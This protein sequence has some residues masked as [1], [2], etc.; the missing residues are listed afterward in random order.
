MPRTRLA[1]VAVP[2]ALVVLAACSSSAKQSTPPTTASTLPN[3][4]STIAG[5]VPT[6]LAPTTVA[7]QTTEPSAPTEPARSAQILAFTGPPSPVL[8]NAPTQVQL[9]WKTRLA[10]KVGLSIDGGAVFSTYPGGARDPLVPLTC[11]G[12][13]HTYTLIAHATNGSIT[14]KSLVLAEREIAT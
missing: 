3:S 11:D 14:T 4:T 1:S 7:P 9:H 13:K 5:T 10:S 12:N 8:C 2:A 6:T